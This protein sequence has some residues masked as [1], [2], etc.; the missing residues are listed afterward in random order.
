MMSTGAQVDFLWSVPSGGE[1]LELI[2][3]WTS[4][5]RTPSEKRG[6]LL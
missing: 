2:S 6:C 4:K 3:L 5:D 1:K